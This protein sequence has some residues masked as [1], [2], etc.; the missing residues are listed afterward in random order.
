MDW[1]TVLW[2]MLLSPKFLPV[3]G[4]VTDDSERKTGWGEV[5][6]VTRKVWSTDINAEFPRLQQHVSLKCP[7]KMIDT[8][9][10]PNHT[11]ILSK[12][13]WCVIA[14]GLDQKAYM[15]ARG[16]S[17]SSRVGSLAWHP[18][19]HEDGWIHMGVSIEI[20]L[21]IKFRFLF[22]IST[23]IH[24]SEYCFDS[25]F[26]CLA[27][28]TPSG[29]LSFISSS[30][31]K[32]IKAG[33]WE[34]DKASSLSWPDV[35]QRINFPLNTLLPSCFWVVFELFLCNSGMALGLCY[36]VDFF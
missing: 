3:E 13:P 14:T 10:S 2:T 36:H 5:T 30:H 21:H 17:G 16:S 12:T 1:Q 19:C 6:R 8:H 27:V 22:T 28:L 15:L 31:Q 26:C 34:G 35:K 29:P 9:G 4:L 25:I 24:Q 11:H 20:Q 7:V 33:A 18:T 23:N 32:W